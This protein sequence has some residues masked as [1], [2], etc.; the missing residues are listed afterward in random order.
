MNINN[1]VRVAIQRPIYKLLDYQCRITPLPKIGC[2]LRVPLG[3]S[4][5]TALVVESNV[6]SEFKNLKDVLEVLDDRPLLDDEM[7]EL[8]Q[9]ASRYYFYPLGEVLFHALPVSLRKGKAVPRL[10]LW[11]SNHL[12]QALELEDLKSAPKQKSML[13]LLQKTEA[14]EQQLD[15]SFGKTWR[16]ILK[17]LDKKELVEYREVDAD[18]T[19]PKNQEAI[20][21]KKQVILTE[22]QKISVPI[23]VNFFRRTD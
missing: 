15:D 13:E 21:E 7:M 10:R 19:P 11:K 9:W 22:E 6:M 17:Q 1:V 14:G 16:N 2:R 4:V 23:L 5:V 8:L 18:F 12:G 20:P 3:N